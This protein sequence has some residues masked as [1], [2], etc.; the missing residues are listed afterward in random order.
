MVWYG[1]PYKRY[2]DQWNRTEWPEINPHMYDQ[3]IFDKGAKNTQEKEE[4][5]Q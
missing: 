2:I 5:L 4:S 3:L 1:V